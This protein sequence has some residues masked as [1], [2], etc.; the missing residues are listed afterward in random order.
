VRFDSG[1]LLEPSYGHTN[2]PFTVEEINSGIIAWLRSASY[3][4]HKVKIMAGTTLR[5][6]IQIFK[7]LEYRVYLPIMEMSL[8]ELIEVKKLVG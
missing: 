4:K 2:S 1:D 6:F 7:G 5:E 3:C 8:D